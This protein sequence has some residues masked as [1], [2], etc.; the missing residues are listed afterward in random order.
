MQW[1]ASLSPVFMMARKTYLLQ[2]EI[3]HNGFGTKAVHV[4]F[5]YTNYSEL[6]LFILFKNSLNLDY[7]ADDVL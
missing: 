1:L 7:R 5:L 2:K 3:L 4:D 6:F